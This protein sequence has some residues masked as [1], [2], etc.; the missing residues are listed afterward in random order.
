M[1]QFYTPIAE[2]IWDMK[3]RL[4]NADGEALDTTI[5]DSWR[6]V[7]RALAVNEDDAEHFEA[8]FYNILEDFKF[9]PA[10]RIMAG[11]GT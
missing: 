10:G 11:A 9:L 1:N 5:E 6:R 3:Y 8:E 4:K 7:A 2:H